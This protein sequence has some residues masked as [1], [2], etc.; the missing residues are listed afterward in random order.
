MKKGNPYYYVREI[1]RVDGKPKVV[2]QVYL[3]SP[4]R[5]FELAKGREKMPDKIQAQ[6]FGALWLANLVEKEIDIA[7][8]IDRVVL[9]E[10]DAEGPP[11]VEYYT[12]ATEGGA[13][14]AVCLM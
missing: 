11:A 13:R 12:G 3:G 2:N 9:P 5:I 10:K 1:A 4:E 6:E 7:G 14:H 8:L